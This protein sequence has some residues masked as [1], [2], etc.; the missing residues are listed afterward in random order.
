VINEDGMKMP[1]FR[2]DDSGAIA[3]KFLQNP[4]KIDNLDD[5][6]DAFEVNMGTNVKYL[7]ICNP[8]W[9]ASPAD[10]TL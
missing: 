8:G 5:L 9:Q 6:Y 2:G 1:V 4:T 3:F 10:L 7:L